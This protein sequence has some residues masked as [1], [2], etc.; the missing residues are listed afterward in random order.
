MSSGMET[1]HLEFKYDPSLLN[2]NYDSHICYDQLNYFTMG[3]RLFFE[4]CMKRCE[5]ISISDAIHNVE[6]ITG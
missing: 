6:M 2:S 5:E 1:S 3:Q 4:M